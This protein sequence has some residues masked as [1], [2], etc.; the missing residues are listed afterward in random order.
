MQVGLCRQKENGCHA[1]QSLL[2]STEQLAPCSQPILEPRS[3]TAPCDTV[4][5][6]FAAARSIAVSPEADEGEA[7]EHFAAEL[8][9]RWGVGDASCNDGVLLLLTLQPRQ[10]CP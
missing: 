4:Q 9:D 10:V 6:A 5:V 7:A 1:N 2:S 8:M 3:M